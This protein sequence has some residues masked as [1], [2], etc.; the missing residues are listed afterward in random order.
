LESLVLLT[1]FQ[2]FAEIL[3]K[4]SHRY[5]EALWYFALA[6]RPSKVREV[7]NLL[8]S[9]SLLQSTVYPPTSE[10]DGHLK[11][12]LTDRAATLEEY[13]KQD[14]EAAQLLGRILSGYATLRTFY[15]LRDSD[16]LE[17]MPPYKA[18]AIRRQAATALMAVISSSDD[19]IRGG[20]YDESRDSVVSEDFLLALLGEASIFVNH[21]PTAISLEQIHTLLKAVEDI[22]TVGSRVRNACAEFFDLA[23]ASAQGLKGSTP[24]DLMKKSTSSLSGSSYIMSGSSMLASQLHRS[25]GSST[26][27]SKEAVKRGWDWRSG[28]LASTKAEDVLRS[29]RLGLAKDLAKLWLEDADNVAIF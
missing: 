13:S 11:R 21:A 1:S 7:L 26:L 22:E 28:F 17:D 19:N 24:A 18:L 14:L 25:I 8:I 15:E 27:L 16:G 23:L 20:L 3:A 9:Y 4:E 2:T 6:H 12:L 5:G 29:L 10:L